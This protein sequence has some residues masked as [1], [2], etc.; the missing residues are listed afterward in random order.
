MVQRPPRRLFTIGRLS[1]LI[2]V[3]RRRHCTMFVCGM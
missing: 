3:L 1:S 2:I